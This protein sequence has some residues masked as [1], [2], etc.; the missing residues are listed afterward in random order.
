MARLNEFAHGRRD[1]VLLDPKDIIIDKSFNYR[2]VNSEESRAHIDWLAKSIRENGV[3]EPIRVRFEEGKITLVNGE[4]R[5][6]ACQR[7]RKAGV[8]V[9]IPAITTKGDEADILAASIVANGALP[10]TQLEYGKAAV[11]L[12]AYGWP[13]E[14][15][16]QYTPPHIQM[17]EAA[18]KR[19]VREA[20]QLHQA[21]I[22][23]K[24]AVA[25][26]V[27]GVKVSPALALQAA[28]RSPLHAEEE[29]ASA[30]RK[31]KEKGR[32]VAKRE[33]G[34]GKATRAREQA[35]SKQEQLLK[36]GDRMA[37]MI[38]VEERVGSEMTAAA[39]A[40]RQIRGEAR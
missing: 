6:L 36:V 28:K 15:V 7:L 34:A 2:D 1:A 32:K 9:F 35:V 12:L 31:A 40:W 29:L 10:P 30:A 18:K 16:A 5:L 20:I 33:K 37:K 24:K 26:G 27:D 14:R 3:Q 4:C 17:S 13:I 39:Q 19:Y 38:L 11:R 25:E 8:E 22:A 23:V 21:P